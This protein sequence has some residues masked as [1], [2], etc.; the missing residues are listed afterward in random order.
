MTHQPIGPAD[1]NEALY[2]AFFEA[3]SN[4]SCLLRNDAPRYTILAATE[5]LLK[6]SGR[7]EKDLIGKPLFEAFPSNP[8]DK[9]DSGEAALRSSLSYVLTNKTPHKL[10]MQRYDVRGENGYFEERY[11]KAENRP[12]FSAAGDVSFIVHT[13]EE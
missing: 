11:W 7:Q 5:Q 4:S 9:A 1:S 12:V 6:L 2:I 8:E 13:T 3:L 10:P